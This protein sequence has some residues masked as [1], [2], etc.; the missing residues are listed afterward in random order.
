[1]DGVTRSQGSRGGMMGKSKSFSVKEAE[2]DNVGRNEL[3]KAK[4]MQRT[5]FESK[6]ARKAGR[7][8]YKLRGIRIGSKRSSGRHTEVKNGFEGR[9]VS[10]EE[11]RMETKKCEGCEDMPRKTASVTSLPSV[12]ERNPLVSKVISEECLPSAGLF[13]HSF[14]RSKRSYSRMRS[15]A[16]MKSGNSNDDDEK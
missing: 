11:G 15:G 7:S 9:E 6:A 10:N 13:L 2:G 16:S 4:T 3:S 14:S 1:M 8:G 5:L 12:P